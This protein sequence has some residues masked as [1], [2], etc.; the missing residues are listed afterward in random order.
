MIP[1]NHNFRKFTAG[2]KLTKL[3]E[4]INHL[5][6]MNNTKLSAKN[7]KE[8]EAL[9]HTVRIYCQDIE[10]KFGIERYAMLVMKSGK[11]HIMEGVEQPNQE[12]TQNAWRKG[13]LH[14]VGD[15]GSWHDQTRGDERKKEKMYIR[16]TKKTTRAGTLSKRYIPLLSLWYNTQGHSWSGPEKILNKLTK[17]QEI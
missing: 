12:K 16:R 9:I 11:R 3:Q 4:K 8:L 13:N 2:Y 10:I 1:L 7:D 6:Y 15:I 14:I 5:M 17:E